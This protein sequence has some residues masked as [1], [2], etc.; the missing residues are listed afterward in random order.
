MKFMFKLKDYSVV[1]SVTQGKQ[2]WK[3]GN[4]YLF[5]YLE[6]PFR[7]KEFSPLRRGQSAPFVSVLA[8]EKPLTE[9]VQA[10]ESTLHL[11]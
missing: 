4:S 3:K 11:K 5:V 10:D 8:L 6:L 1:I 7:C 9:Q 2:V